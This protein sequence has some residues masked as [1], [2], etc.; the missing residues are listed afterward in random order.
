[1]P[2]MA[3]TCAR[4]ASLLVLALLLGAGLAPLPAR[5][6]SCWVSGSAS[7]DFGSVSSTSNTDSQTTLSLTCQAG[8]GTPQ[9]QPTRFRVCI[10]VG[11]GN[12]TGMAPRRMTNY[13]GAYM[14]YDLYSNGGRTRLIGPLGSSYPVYSRT[15]SIPQSQ[16]RTINLPLYGRVP[17]GQSL[18][19]N[20]AFQ[21]FPSGSVVRY[22]YGYGSTPSVASCVNGTAGNLGGTGEAT[23][24]WSGVR[25][26]V[27]NTCRVMVATDMDFGIAGNLSTARDQTS[28]I[29]L[30]CPTGANWQVN[31][32]NGSHASGNTRHMASGGNR[33]TYE[34]YRDAN[35]QN[36]WG[37]QP[38]NGV[39]GTG[40]NGTQSLTVYGRI[41]AQG[42][43]PRG[44]YT[45][46][47]TVR[48][49]Y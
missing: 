46:T 48:L 39:S 9:N 25:A 22:S 40:N 5:A 2:M 30:Q 19:A 16:S 15:Y 18:P 28:T 31:L 7:L 34:L 26:N 23:F 35:H 21:G 38:N 10:F 11:E 8:Y 33:I 47:I 29:Q 49:T 24:G 44:T 43:V 6:Q 42:T 41:D 27:A 12:P 4:L 17:A 32:D 45:D 36:R 3:A 37:N 20:Y 1:M 14:S 13:N